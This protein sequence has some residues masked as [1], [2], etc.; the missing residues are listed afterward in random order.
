MIITN[1]N[2]YLPKSGYTMSR[3]SELICRRNS[4][5]HAIQYRSK[6]IKN[7]QYC[8]MTIPLSQFTIN[9]SRS[10]DIKYED[11]ITTIFH[12]LP[13]E[14]LFW[15]LAFLDASDILSLVL[16]AKSLYSI[17]ISELDRLLCREVY[18]EKLTLTF[19]SEHKPLIDRVRNYY[20]NFVPS[21]DHNIDMNSYHMESESDD[22]FNNYSDDGP[23]CY[24]ISDDE[25]DIYDFYIPTCVYCDLE[26]CCCSSDP[27]SDILN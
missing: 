21:F 11:T 27:S 6:L 19:I 25:S 3:L 26:Y 1:N 18:S 2:K 20:P 14:L 13:P 24:S 9:E 7:K 12:K 4:T 5:R 22:D 17:V 10:H 16:S 8:V 23:I 15:I